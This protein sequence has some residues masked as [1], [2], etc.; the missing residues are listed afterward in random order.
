[1]RPSSRAS[2]SRSTRAPVAR[3]ANICS[4]GSP[5][6][7]PPRRPT[8]SPRAGELRFAISLAALGAEDQGR[9]IDL[10]LA[11]RFLP[12][13]IAERPERYDAWACRWLARWLTEAPGVTID[14]AAE[15]AAS[16]AD[17]PAEPSSLESIKHLTH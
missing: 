17:L 10:E 16:L 11:L 1:M 9:P 2:T 13:V 5:P 4:Y 15:V 8:R 14:Q 12:V 3:D 7:P 6:L